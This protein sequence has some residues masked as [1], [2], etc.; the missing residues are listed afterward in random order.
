LIVLKK[1][2]QAH[3]EPTAE[4]TAPSARHNRGFVTSGDVARLAGVSRSAVSRT[5]T[6]GASVSENTRRR[7]HD[8]ANALGYRINRLAQSLIGDT[9]N[10]VGIVGANL[11]APFMA[12]QLDA[13]SRSL[14]LHGLQTL[15]LNAAEGGDIER[16]I[17]L[18]L[19]FRVRAVVV[20]SGRPPRQIIEECAKNQVRVILVNTTADLEGADTVLI[21]DAAGGRLSANRLIAAGCRS[22]AVVNGRPNTYNH[23][24][25]AQSFM[26]RIEESGCLVRI[27]QADASDYNAGLVAAGQMLAEGKI[28]GVFC[29]TDLTALGFMDGLRS[30]FGRRVP[31]DVSVIGF[32]DIPQAS[33]ELYRL[34]TIRQPID[35]IVSAV[36]TALER[37]EPRSGGNTP[38]VVPVELIE[39]Q[40]VRAA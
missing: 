34:T 11:A 39:R 29:T 37:S 4:S 19:E 31:E 13:L 1:H 28:D 6:P 33:W 15:L 3:A 17:S 25:R 16:L 32:D 7:V 8:A 35:G 18:M 2:S 12:A 38:H 40:T 21:D 22:C 23:K 14:L 5:F 24:L 30:R 9:S 26:E 36:I 27:W 10:L 20:M